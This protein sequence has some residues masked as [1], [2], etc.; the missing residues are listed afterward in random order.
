MAEEF[1]P[2]KIEEVTE[3]LKE[4]KKVVQDTLELEGDRKKEQREFYDSLLEQLIENRTKLQDEIN[5]TNNLIAQD[6]QALRDAESKGRDLRAE[7]MRENLSIYRARLDLLEEIKKADEE[8]NEQIEESV[9]RQKKALSGFAGV[10][11]NMGDSVFASA[12]KTVAAMKLLGMEVPNIFGKAREAF[13]VLD[14][15]RRELIPFSKTIADA[16][17]LQ[18]QLA[19][20]FE[21]SRIPIT[22][23][24]QAAQNAAGDFS[25]FATESAT[26]QSEIA[27]FTAQLGLLGVQGGGSMIESIIADTGVEGAKNAI[28]VL[29][30]L[31][32]QM[33]ELGVTPVKFFN[34]FQ[35]LIPQF[36]M[37]GEAAAMNIAKVSYMAQKMK[38]DVGTITGFADNF[39]GYTGAAR[40]AQRINAVFGMNIIDNPAELVRTFYTTGPSGVAMLVKQKILESGIDIEAMLAGPAGAA[41][42]GA[43]SPI[44]GD[45]QGAGRFLRAEIG[46]EDLADIGLGASAKDFDKNIAGIIPQSKQIEALA[47]NMAVT[48]L[49]KLGIGLG[50]TGVVMDALLKDLS[51]QFAEASSTA[52]EGKAFEGVKKTIAEKVKDIFG[53][54]LGETVQTTPP[55]GGKG[56]TSALTEAAAQSA[57]ASKSLKISADKLAKSVEILEKTMRDTRSPGEITRGTAPFGQPGFGENPEFRLVLDPSGRKGLVKIITDA[58][59]GKSL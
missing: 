50:E 1:D 49:K 19:A 3:A 44:L 36:A 22:D 21:K 59:M 33:K 13:T 34:D 58:A 57:E 31:T 55:P 9:E 6:L 53:V 48:L 30:G 2:S 7:Q 27:T 14:D 46:A 12:A 10:F 56:T 16:N 24:G 43:L 20:R 45:P 8:Q 52:M 15:A 17:D 54:T 32:V 23:L 29:K 5:A 11:S 18:N 37:F 51:M 26:V 38:V 28:G 39:K 35:K 41:K 47:E 40:A 42:L 25:L 4:Y